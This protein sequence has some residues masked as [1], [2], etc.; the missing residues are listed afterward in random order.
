MR[1]GPSSVFRAADRMIR[2]ANG[3]ATSVIKTADDTVSIDA[4]P[5]SDGLSAGVKNGKSKS[6]NPRCKPAKTM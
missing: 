4:A 1:A 2:D 3:A 5:Y 6:D